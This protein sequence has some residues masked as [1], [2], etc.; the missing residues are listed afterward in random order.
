MFTFNNTTYS[1]NQIELGALALGAFTGTNI[2]S[3]G[4]VAIT[5]TVTAPGNTV[6]VA[7][8][9]PSV[10]SGTYVYEGYFLNQ[11][12]PEYVFAQ[13]AFGLPINTFAVGALA[14]TVG[15]ATPLITTGSVPPCFL[16]G[17]MIATPDGEV[18]VEDLSI[19]DL[20]LSNTGEAQ[21]VMWIGKRSYAG[22]FLASNKAVHPVRFRAGSLGDGLPRRDLL[23]SPEH[24]MLLDGTLIAAQYLVNGVSIVREHGLDR[25]DYLHIELASHDVILAEGAATESF[26]DDDNRALFQNAAEFYELYHDAA[27]VPGMS[28]PRAEQGPELEGIWRRLMALTGETALAA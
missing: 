21:P 10:L 19:G 13:T 28:T 4:N 24:A 14:A 16:P 7:S 26:L 17:T 18:A 9:D 27:P 5:G 22:R 23:V 6:T 2:G 11:G 1:N 12:T 15:V 20:V 3:I 25:V 8:T